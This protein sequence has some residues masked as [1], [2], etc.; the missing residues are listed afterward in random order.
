MKEDFPTPG[1][2]E[3]IGPFLLKKYFM[4]IFFNGNVWI[5]QLSGKFEKL[6]ALAASLF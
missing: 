2:P 4:T 6:H 5:W 3:F 1:G